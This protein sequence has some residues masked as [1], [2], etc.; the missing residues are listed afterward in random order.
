MTAAQKGRL[1]AAIALPFLLLHF[2]AQADAAAH[3][4]DRVTH[5]L[6]ACL[7]EPR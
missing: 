5:V 3:T 6:R 1:A 4:V 7:S 2:A